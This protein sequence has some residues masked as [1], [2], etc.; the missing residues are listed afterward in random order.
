MSVPTNQN[1]ANPER[2]DL[3]AR[4]DESG[5]PSE[6]ETQAAPEDSAARASGPTI[7]DLLA[8]VPPEGQDL[9]SRA[10]HLAAHLHEGQKRV[11]GDPYILHPLNVALLLTELNMDPATVAAGLLH[12]VLEDTDITLE[13]LSA[14]FPDPVPQ[15]VSGVTKITKMNFQT[16]REAQIENLRIMFL[17][18]AQDIRVVIVKLC[19]RLHNMKTLKFLPPEKRI[20]IS[21]ETMDIYAPLANRLGMASIKGEIEDLAMRW[22]Q[23]EVYQRLTR[24]I[25]TKRRER[26]QLVEESIEYLRK[27]LAAQFPKLAITGRPKH[28]YSIYK[29]MKAQ[30]LTFQQIYDLNALRIL[31]E[32]EG[33]CYAILGMVHQI[34]PPVPHRFKDY[35]GAPK[36]NRY[37]S[38]HTTVVG[39]RGAITEIQ[40]R[41]RDMHQIAE[42]GIAA[43]WKYKE[44][45][46]P[47][48]PSGQQHDETL[49]W[50]RQLTEWITDPNEPEGLMEA[51]RKDVFADR[52]LCFTP[53]GD[54]IELPAKATPIDF[55]YSI[56]T[57]VGQQC[58]GAKINGRMVNL[59]TQLQ[60]GDIVEVITASNGHPSRDWLD[61]VVTGRARSKIKHWLKS[62]NIDIWVEQGRR[63]I[64]RLLQERNIDVPGQELESRLAA[65]LNV[66]KLQS[67]DDLLVEIGFGS[68]SPMAALTRINP[69]WATL[70]RKSAR[71]TGAAPKRKLED[72]II[73]EGAE[74]APTKL[75]HCCS[76]I[77]GDEIVAYVTRGRGITVHQ[78]TCPFVTR[79][80]EDGEEAQRLLHA[81]WNNDGSQSFSV[82]LYVESEDRSGLLNAL[83]GVIT[84]SG[85]FIAGC[86]TKSNMQRGT[87]VLQFEVNVNDVNQLHRVLEALRSERGVIK[88]E[89]KRRGIG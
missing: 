52:V 25:S 78:T 36:Q 14:Q 79:A 24:Q 73:V 85:L 80:R 23:P 20:A 43:H 70:P 47:A 65:L 62:Q 10:Y 57:K 21:Q 77:P 22:L 63:A 46:A 5:N 12:D 55:A 66:Y 60:H 4:T 75:A 6:P 48:P 37:Q 67:V 59:R 86:H 40:I 13:E 28:F 53:K 88:A 38:I 58:V 76:P 15:I 45:V 49:A 54:V 33:E 9:V 81:D 68:I 44:G 51:L 87:A 1:V 56:H 50:L 34:W 64:Q 32:T 7:E 27:Y 74:G 2:D 30:G 35:I 26:E 29:K 17:A 3:P 16:T 18:M 84:G 82:T 72:P 31:C 42:Y 39:L 11:S 41:T 89:R 83:T 71:R 8:R 61:Y 19:D 69:E